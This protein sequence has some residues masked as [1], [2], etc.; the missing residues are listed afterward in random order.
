MPGNLTV[1]IGYSRALP[2]FSCS[3]IGQDDVSEDVIGST[4]LI[5]TQKSG[6]FWNSLWSKVKG[7]FARLFGK[8][9]LA[10]NIDPKSMFWCAGSVKAVPAIHNLWAKDLSSVTTTVALYIDTLLPAKSTVA[11]FLRGGVDGIKDSTG[12]GIRN[13]DLNKPLLNDVCGF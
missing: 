6:G 13:P 7:I 5:A 9:A 2:D 11:V 10:D 3:K 12:I 8:D 4:L 1:A